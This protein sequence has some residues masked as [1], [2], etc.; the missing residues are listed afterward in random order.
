[1]LKEVAMINTLQT[2][3]AAI[4]DEPDD[5][6]PRLVYADCCEESGDHDRAE[7]IRLQLE[8]HRA[9]AANQQEQREI[10]S[11]RHR[12]ARRRFLLRRTNELL[13][14]T[15]PG[16][17]LAWLDDRW[18]LNQDEPEE[19]APRRVHSVE[20]GGAAALTE[21]SRSPQRWTW[22]RGFVAAVCCSLA[23]WLE[24]GP[25]L[26]RMQP[27]A[28]VH[29]LDRTGKPQAA[30]DLPW[31]AHLT[32]REAQAALSRTLLNWARH[33]KPWSHLVLLRQAHGVPDRGQCRP[34]PV[35]A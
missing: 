2:I 8:L 22:E 5:D 30:A 35:T 24:H 34:A 19:E 20:A 17:G 33:P 21:E 9:P 16:N 3:L 7:F 32:G 14:N 26:V 23:E 4:L 28:R 29:L 18:P 1:L 25:A 27:L 15:G 6:L 10:G 31:L 12:L 11:H 13:A